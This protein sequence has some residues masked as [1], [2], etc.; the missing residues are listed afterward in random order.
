MTV[1]GMLSWSMMAL[2][3]SPWFQKRSRFAATSSDRAKEAP[4]LFVVPLK[5]S[6]RKNKCSVELTY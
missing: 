2:D 4:P 3:G 6:N 5:P 1:L